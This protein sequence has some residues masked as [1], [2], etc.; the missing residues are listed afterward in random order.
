MIESEV[1][2]KWPV[3]Y[4]SL[5]NK[6]RHNALVQARKYVTA[7]NVTESTPSTSEP[8]ISREQWAE[9]QERI[10]ENQEDLGEENDEEEGLIPTM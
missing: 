1:K 3:E 2:E 8:I 5:I 10:A 9:I 4:E 6:T 7:G